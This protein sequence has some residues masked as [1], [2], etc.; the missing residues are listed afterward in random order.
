MTT[1]GQDP[2]DGF[3]LADSFQVLITRIGALEGAIAQQTN[4]TRAQLDAQ[5]RMSTGGGNR[6]ANAAAAEGLMAQYQPRMRESV[7]RELGR[8][9]GL[10]PD[11]SVGMTR[12]SGL[13][14][15]ASLQGL[16]R[17]GAQRLGEWIAGEPL[18][19]P[20]A[21]ARGGATAGGQTPGAGAPAAPPSAGPSPAAQGAGWTTTPAPPTASAAGGWNIPQSAWGM[22]GTGTPIAGSGAGGGGWAPVPNSGYGSGYQGSGRGSAPGSGGG[23]GGTPGG[24]GGAPGG[25]A[26]PPPNPAAALGAR[27]AMSGGSLGGIGSMLRAIP[28]VGLGTDVVNGVAGFY[29][30]QR[31]A[32]RSYQEIE[33]TTNLQGQTER[34]N[35]LVYR[36][37]MFGQLPEGAAAQAFMGVT[38]MGY[39]S[40]ASAQYAQLQNRSSALDFISSNYNGTGTDVQQSLAILQTVS[41]NAEIS[42]TRTASAINT[43]SQ[44]AGQAGD[45]ALQARDNFNNLLQSAISTG[46]GA[47]SPQIAGTIATM[48]ATMGKPLAGNNFSGLT[49][50]QMQYQM[51]GQYGLT[52]SQVESLYSTN[53]GQYMRMLS[54]AQ[55]NAIGQALGS[56]SLVNDLKSMISQAG[57][58]NALKGNGDLATQLGTQF[59]AQYQAANP[60]LDTNALA[61][62]L[63]QFAGTQLNQNNVMPWLVNQL[64]GVNEA[65]STAGGAGGAATRSVSNPGGSA[66]GKYGLAQSFSGTGGRAAALGLTTGSGQ[67]WQ[68]VLTAANS[69]AAQPYL[70]AESK[71]QQRSPVLEALLQNVPSGSQVAVR[72]SA[73]TRVMSFADAMQ[74]YPQELQQGNVDFYSA[75]GQNLGNVGGFTGGLVNQGASVASELKQKAGSNLGT[76]LAQFQKSNPSVTGGGVT[77]GLTQEAQQLVTMLHGNTAAAQGAVPAASYIASASR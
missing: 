67:S 71:S 22:P 27:V 3:D 54:G 65:S 59:L 19:G 63:S 6:G 11:P 64:A 70:T 50:T 25:G 10:P 4:I 73:G 69:A 14:A 48:Q 58:A 68:Q 44:A 51:A 47:A 61:Q 35:S 40:A 42:L 55:G 57:G 77:I 26:P 2:D 49:S 33:G 74:Y 76:S 9:G 72:T 34:W 46:G 28:G 20:E 30:D 8:Q 37:S 43:L 32:G 53:P 38:A 13:G 12:V 23:G 36:A 45:N 24:S 5:M 7:L 52:P 17:Y 31:E 66:V 62:Y 75:S 39:N 56:P 1:P 41:Q 15:L 29:Q 18:Y 21:A 16:Q 60:Q